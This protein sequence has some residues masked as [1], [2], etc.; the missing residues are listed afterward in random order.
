MDQSLRFAVNRL[1][2]SGLDEKAEL[3][4]QIVQPETNRPGN[5]LAAAEPIKGDLIN[6]PYLTSPASKAPTCWIGFAL[7]LCRDGAPFPVEVTADARRIA[8]DAVPTLSDRN[9]RGRNTRD[10]SR[11]ISGRQRKMSRYPAVLMLTML[12]LTCTGCGG[13]TRAVGVVPNTLDRLCEDT[14]PPERADECKAP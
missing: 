2:T 1:L 3:R 7:I 8:R 12:A 4:R 13:L 14:R 10:R 5:R 11:W 9:A 6:A